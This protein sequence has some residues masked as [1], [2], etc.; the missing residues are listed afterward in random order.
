MY[1][2]KNT[3]VLAHHIMAA[4]GGFFGVYALLNRSLT[5]GSSE[6]SNLIY[7]FVAG[8]T[9]DKREFAIRLLAFC[10]YVGGMM[11]ATAMEKYVRN[12]DIRLLSLVVDAV[13]CVVLAQIPQDVHE[14]IALYPM[15][16]ATAVQW[17]AF[18]NAAGFSSSTIFSTNNCRQC[19]SALT[20]YLQEHDKKHLPAVAVFGGTLIAFHIGVIYCWICMQV[21][22]L[23][24]AYACLPI[25]ALGF[26]AVARDRRKP[27]RG[28][29]A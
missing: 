24:S 16:F 22:G 17:L 27:C 25:V 29:A 6:T 11:F 14:V 26:A 18:T 10:I 9:R 3:E 13:C 2:L 23:K 1:G 19:F 5:F 7:L 12:R 15:F 4:A 21:W 28:K 20:R 8:L